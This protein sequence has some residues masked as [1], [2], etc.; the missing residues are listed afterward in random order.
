[1]KT[2]SM[3]TAVV[4]FTSNALSDCPG[5]IDGDRA[6][7]GADLGLL[8]AAWGPC[9]AP[10]PADIDG[11][12]FVGGGDIGGLLSAFGS[13]PEEPGEGPFNYGEALQKA[14][15]FYEAQRAGDLPADGRI[16]WRADCFD[17]E[18]EQLNGSYPVDAAIRNRYMDAG[19]TPTFVLPITSAMTTLAW[20]GIEFGD[21]WRSTGQFD[22]LLAALRWHADWCIAAHPR[23]DVFCGQIGQGGPSHAFWGPPEI[24]EQATGYQPRIWWLNPENPGSEPAAEAAAFL[25]AFSML[26][27][28]RDPAYAAE[29]LR[30]ARELYAFADEHQGRY[31][32]SI[33]DAVPFYNSWS[34]YL[35]E[36]AWA[37]AWLHRA[38]G[39]ASYLADAE[40]HY[41]AASPDPAWSQSWDGKINGA[42]VLLQHLTG[43]DS[44]R[45][46][47]ER[48][49]DHWLPGG[50][51]AYT[52]GGLAWL[53]T[54]GSLRYAANTSF[55]AFVHAELN[56]DPDGRYREFG[57]SQID[58]ILG[59]NPRS[60][61][62]VCGFGENPPR[63]P[64]HR[65]AH[66]SWRDW[67]VD[68]APNRHVLWG[69]LVGGPASADD[70]DYEDDRNDYIANEVACD[71][72]AG[73]TAA[74]SRMAREYGGT[75]LPDAQFPPHEDSYG[76]EMFV[77]ASL[78]EDEPSFSR[79]RCVFNNRSA[80]PARWSD[81][82]S[83]RIFVDLT[84]TVAAG[85]GPD[86]VRVESGFLDG[87]SLGPLEAWDPARNIYSVEVSYVGESFGPGK[88]TDY[89]R[90]SQITIGL[91]PSA[92]A[93]AWNP[94][95]DPSLGVLA[96]GQSAIAKTEAI[97]VYEAGSLVFG[98]E[99]SV[100]CND[101]GIADDL[102]IADGAPDLDGNGRP[103]ECD[104]D[105]DGDGT[106][107]AAEIDQGASDCDA[108]GTPDACQQPADCDGDGSPDACEIADG[109]ASDCD[110]NGVPDACDIDAGSASDNDGDGVPDRCQIAGILFEFSV[111]DQWNSGF[112]ASLTIRNLSGADIS[113]WEVVWDSPYEVVNA[114]NS[115]LRSSSGDSTTVVN[116]AW[117]GT[118]PDGG[119]VEIGFQANGVPVPPTNVTVNAAGAEPG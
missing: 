88:G 57:E 26:L 14:I 97:A 108:D 105:C 5:D 58:Y 69:A 106:P 89:L 49:L 38:T 110:G 119:S 76:E 73:F 46:D 9:G 41:A 20:S 116:E 115:V 96:F 92:P 55:L 68:P 91:D 114:W 95:N 17:A 66:G 65:G 100:D 118:I 67:I 3:L 74:L 21:G 112:N 111:N 45:A 18:L 107:D 43:R 34:G 25:A 98:E 113:G 93:S 79:V 33:P 56:G 1:M 72:N 51:I 70:Y 29:A 75:P 59:D 102:D 77:E 87:G 22:E 44:Y 109:S 16:A 85:L 81:Q 23:P 6:V 11:D 84:E 78:I 63:N 28:D 42:A 80:W 12:G 61:S 32:D 53:D 117:N 40:A 83:F 4:L 64:H 50:G 90:E 35:D 10:C 71:Y 101:N 94:S 8:F 47:A 60:S 19:D 52:P 104:P 99:G 36:L 2:A 7:T 39:E 82:L 27:Q 30:H 103:D 86:D 37:A 48:H 15:T 24:H 62:Y 13:C 31:V 54:W